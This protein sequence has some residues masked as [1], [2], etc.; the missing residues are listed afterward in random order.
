MD[1]EKKGLRRGRGKK[2]EKFQDRRPQ[3]YKHWVR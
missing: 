1:D 3:V 2:E